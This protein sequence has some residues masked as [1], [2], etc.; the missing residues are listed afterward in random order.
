M[1]E[2][3]T[4]DDD[5]IRLSDILRFVAAYKGT[6]AAAVLVALLVAAVAYVLVPRTYQLVVDIHP[7]RQAE[8]ARYS[9]LAAAD[10][11]PYDREGLFKEFASYVQDY[12]LLTKAAT[13]VAE[14]RAKTDQTDVADAVERIRFTT[15][16]R[17]PDVLTMTIRGESKEYV[18]TLAQEVLSAANSAFADNIVEEVSKEADARQEEIEFKKTALEN[19]I[20]ARRKTQSD[21]E[22]D[23]LAR[24]IEQAKIARIVGI[25]KPF[26]LP[27][28]SGDTNTN[29]GSAALSVD[30]ASP[31]S[32]PTYLAGYV[33]LDEAIRQ[34]RL[35]QGNDAY[36][37]NLRNLER[38]ILQLE[39]NKAA[40]R[41][42]RLLAQS[43][44]GKPDSR[45][46]VWYELNA[47]K[48]RKVFPSALIFG[49]ASVVLGFALGLALAFLRSGNLGSRPEIGMTPV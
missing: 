6:I 41:I 28:D 20:D 10:A 46:L 22:N 16:T 43:G 42:K 13:K 15:N 45:P 39:S 17:A 40:E 9:M 11:F 21:I 29:N 34:L 27:S 24:F 30:V 1:I 14:T 25:D 19:E 48:T 49:G 12:A 8:L 38:Q 7:A 44:L 3:E 36:I 4:R 37:P 5:E 33:A 18:A 26:R 47:N 31:A 32:E 23:L 35:R 2:A